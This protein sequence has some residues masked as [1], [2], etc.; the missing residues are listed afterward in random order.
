MIMGM[1]C[2]R[3][4]RNDVNVFTDDVSA[5]GIKFTCQAPLEKDEEVALDVPIGN[6]EYKTI[7]GRIAWIKKET[8]GIEGG[9]EFFRMD[10]GTKSEWSKFIQRNAEG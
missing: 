9:I 7:P 3:K 5:G 8:I 4:D 10:E 1:V 2:R 6:G